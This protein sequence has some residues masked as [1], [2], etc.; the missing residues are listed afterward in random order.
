M[1]GHFLNR[2]V[3]TEHATICYKSVGHGSVPSLA[4]LIVLRVKRQYYL[5]TQYLNLFSLNISHFAVNDE[6]SATDWN[7][8]DARG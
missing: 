3:H 5:L 6:S 2:F 8:L 4:K 1:A 7:D